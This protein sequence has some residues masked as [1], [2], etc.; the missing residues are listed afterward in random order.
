MRIGISSR[1]AKTA[2]AKFGDKKLDDIEKIWHGIDPPYENLFKWLCNTGPIPE[3]DLKNTFNPMMLANPLEDKDFKNLN[4]NDFVAE[5]KW[6]GIRVQIIINDSNIKIFSRTGDDISL[7]FP[8]IKSLEKNMVILDGE[9]LVGR[10]YIP[11]NFNSLQKRLNRK[12]VSLKH[13]DDFPAFV[14]LYDILYLKNDDL[15]EKNWEERRNLLENWYYKNKNEFFDLS[16][17][18]NFNS[19]KNLTAIRENEII[20]EQ[21]EGLMI[22]RKDSIY[23][24]GRKKGFWFKWKSDPKTIDAVLT[25]AMRGHGSRTNLYTDYTFAL[26]NDEIL[27]TFAKAYSGLTDMEI[28][29]VDRFIKQN[30]IDRFGPVRQ[31]KPELVFEIAFEGIASSSRHKSGF[32][33][34]FPRIL[35]WRHDK[36]IADANTINDLKQFLR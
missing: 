33:V 15:R 11:M 19:W 17:I 8:E 9:L 28:K 29:K 27:V 12:K 4:C 24:V 26:W 36:K 35:R 5:W 32:A 23:S 7:S 10:N 22:K 34:R 21:H 6:D 18:I 30:T 16:K 13:I 25:F 1:L 14:K 2:L 31:V 3:I 20:D